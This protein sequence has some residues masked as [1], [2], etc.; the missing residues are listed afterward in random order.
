MEDQDLRADLIARG[1]ERQARFTWAAT[2]RGTLD[3]YARAW[4]QKS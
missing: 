2:A 1:R 3:S 4:A